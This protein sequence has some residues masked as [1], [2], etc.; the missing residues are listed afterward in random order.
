VRVVGRLKQERWQNKEG[1]SMSRVIIVAE[2]V[3]YRAEIKNGSAE[4]EEKNA[5][6]E[7][8]ET[9]ETLVPSF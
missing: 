3:E 9:E 8:T 6:E 4:A 1:N 5:S 7:F 2:H